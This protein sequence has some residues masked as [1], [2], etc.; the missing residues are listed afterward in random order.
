MIDRNPRT[1]TV[2]HKH[3][4]T[5][6]TLL[7]Y[8]GSEDWAAVYRRAL[9]TEGKTPKHP[10]APPSSGWIDRILEARHSP[11]RRA[12]YTFLFDDIPSNTSVHFCRHVHAQPFVSSLRN[13]RQEAI[14]GDA[15]PRCSPVQMILDVN[16]EELMVMANKR[17]CAKAA[18]ITRQIMEGM[19]KLAGE[20]T[21]EISRFLVP[22]C[23]YHGHV[24]HEMRS[25]GRCPAATVFR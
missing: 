1:T 7:E 25:C 16:A 8:P 19:A 10:E 4:S 14:D 20:A 23:E 24:C 2:E 3:G 21:P 22:M 9:I 17:L 5:K 13:D 15:A 18:E 11:I 12:T 6:I